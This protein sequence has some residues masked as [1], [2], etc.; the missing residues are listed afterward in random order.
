M[1]GHAEAAGWR[2]STTSPT[3]IS[4]APHYITANVKS[5]GFCR[6][7]P[8]KQT[9]NVVGGVPCVH[10]SAGTIFYEGISFGTTP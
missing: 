4:H 6:L 8:Q 7:H 5:M 9:K 1:G 3:R 2:P 10:P